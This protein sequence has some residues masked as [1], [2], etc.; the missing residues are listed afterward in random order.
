M[1]GSGLYLFSE[2][3]RHLYV[4]RTDRLRARILEHG[5]P[6]S[7][8]SSAAFAFKLARLKAGLT[9]ASYKPTNSR[10]DLESQDVFGRFF[11][12]AKYRVARMQI[13]FVEESDPAKQALLEIY[14]A[15]SLHTKYN[16]FK[17]T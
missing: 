8:H 7:T 5:R 17:N 1:P 14:A 12:E 4:G 13:R 3:G 9:R 10:A 16:E 6:S 11:R 15:V 2:P